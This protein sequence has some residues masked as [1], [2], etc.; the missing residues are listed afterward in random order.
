MD[1]KQR[2]EESLTEA[3]RRQAHALGFDHCRF[4]QV[5][6]AAHADFFETWVELGRP[7]EMTYLA[8]NQEK[9]RRPELLLEANRPARTLVVLAVDYHQFDLPPTLRND[10]S[11]GVIASYA[12]GD[13]YHDVIRPLLY[14]LD[15]F[16]AAAS[17][18]KTQ[19][20]CLV[21]TGPVL[22][23]DW[24][25][26][27]GIGFMGK[28]CCTIHPEQ[29]SW[30]FLATILIP[31]AL[32]YAPPPPASVAPV[33]VEQVAAGLP[34]SGDYGTW[35]LDARSGT[36]GRCTR[37]LDACP[38]EAFVG[39]YHLDPQ[40][41]ISYWT[42]EARGPIP[43]KLRPAFGNRI[44]GCDICQ[45]VCPWNARLPARTP[46]PAGLAAQS[47][48]IAPPLLEGFESASPY[49]LDDAAF[50]SRFRRSPVKRPKRRGML[51]N[52]CIALGNW[53]DPQAIDALYLALQ[54]VEALGRGHAAWALGEIAR[55]HPASAA[56]QALAAAL[57]AE[58]DAWVQDEIHRALAGQG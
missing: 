52:V 33:T 37:C 43:R 12:W 55:R 56:A 7:G 17:G 54:D 9:R 53:G 31:E 45:E 40:R 20:K 41:C 10:P 6:T 46:L 35:R 49:W 14:E 28:N 42:I 1:A 44:F 25:Q 38:T 39:P 15:A 26:H 3:T 11:R 27:A 34:D 51:R 47:G 32:A 50:R 23:R 16:I 19:G 48:R 2:N 24:A 8:R 22:E 5:E 36:C 21:D 30:C 29:G 57:P 13:D 58:R 4:V 18:R